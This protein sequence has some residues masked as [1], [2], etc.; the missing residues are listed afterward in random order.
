MSA[1]LALRVVESR[2][3]GYKRVWKGSVVTAFVNP[4]LFLLAMGQGLGTLVEQG[5][6][7]VSYIDFIAPGLLAATAMQTA[8]GEATWP[9]MAGIKWLR[10]YHAVLATPI[11]VADLV[12]GELIWIS[13]RCLMACLAFAL[14]AG[15]MGAASLGG[16]LAAIPIVVLTGMA[17]AAPLVAFTAVAKN[18]SRLSSLFRFAIIPMFLFSGTFFPI[19]QLPGWLQPVA[20]V[21][22]LWHGVDLARS[23]A[24]DIP[25][26][27]GATFHVAYLTVWVVAGWYLAHKTLRKAMVI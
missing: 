15:L 21:T 26:H 17:F 4:I 6:G 19:G 3:R 25:A 22:P 13:V 8:A 16:L 18:E 12:A 27:I 2:A 7:S 23:I 9:V 24:L 1:P 11:G 20:Y 10:V 5:V 14:M